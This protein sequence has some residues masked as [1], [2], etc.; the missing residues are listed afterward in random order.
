MSTGG[1]PPGWYHA[2][3]DPPGT[4]RY[5]NGSAWTE[6]PRPVQPETPTMPDTPDFGSSAPGS[7]MPVMGGS[8]PGSEM[9]EVGGAMPGSDMPVMGGGSTAGSDMPVM[10][11]S[12]GPAQDLPGAGLPPTNQPPTNMPP[13][14]G[15][16]TGGMP[17]ASSPGMST[18]FPGGIP[19]DA[20]PGG[21]GAPAGGYAPATYTESSQATVALVLSIVGFFCCLTAPVGAFLGWQEKN[22]IDAGRRDPSKR[23]QAM[24]ALI[25]G[26]VFTVLAVLGVLFFVAVGSTA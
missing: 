12:T 1:A 14:G 3:G 8:T 20:T 19:S 24:A 10:G 15:A 21:F 18:G 4:E 7:D 2:E 25:I 17:P 26:L 13:L 6:G 5:W 11:G 22:A 9:P 16:P 23:G